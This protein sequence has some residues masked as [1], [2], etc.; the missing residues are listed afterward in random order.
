MVGENTYTVTLRETVGSADPVD[1]TLKI[2]VAS[3]IPDDDATLAAIRVDNTSGNYGF[4]YLDT[5]AIPGYISDV[6]DEGIEAHAIGGVIDN[7][8]ETVTITLPFGMKP[9]DVGMDSSLDGDAS[10]VFAPTSVQAKAVYKYIDEEN[11]E[12][13]VTAKTGVVNRY[14]VFFK[15]EKVFES[16]ANSTNLD[17]LEDVKSGVAKLD[18]AIPGGPSYKGAAGVWVPEFVAAEGVKRIMG[19]SKDAGVS[20]TNYD[21]G[22]PALVFGKTNAPYGE[23]LETDKNNGILDVKQMLKLI[24]SGLDCHKQRWLRLPPGS[25]QGQ[26]LRCMGR[27]SCPC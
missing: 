15:Q 11:A 23:Y 19:D 6:T 24:T 7:V 3:S 13:T 16:F 18:V 14:K 22:I 12:V 20:P 8:N 5:T 21:D 2:T 1:H 9:V 17:E 26:P 25:H 10:H 4:G 27:G